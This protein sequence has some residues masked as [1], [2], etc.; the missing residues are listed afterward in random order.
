MTITE[1]FARSMSLEDAMSPNNLLAYEMNGEPLPPLH[2]FPLRLIV[3]GWYGIANVKWLTRIE[4][5]DRRYMGNF[6][7]RDY[8]TIREEERDGQTLWTFTSV[9]RTRLKSAPA[10]VTRQRDQYQIMGGRGARPSPR[11]RSAS[12]RSPGSRPRSSPR[13]RARTPG[14]S[15]PSIGARL[16]LASTPSPRAR[17]PRTARCSRPRTIPSWPERPPTGRAT[18][19]S[20]GTS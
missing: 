20:P 1:Q 11:Q 3:P 9:G 14:P 17:S 7:A 18:A 19:R 8:V 6:M 10:K 4:V 13:T 2:G 16:L 12:M 15:G 5:L